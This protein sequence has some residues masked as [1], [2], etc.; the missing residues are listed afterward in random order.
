MIVIALDGIQ[1]RKVFWKEGYGRGNSYR[2]I[3]VCPSLFDGAK[4]LLG[5]LNLS[6]ESSR[7]EHRYTYFEEIQA[8]SV[9]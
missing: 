5:S 6:L 9:I 2:F 8:L 4:V 3:V 1:L 7:K